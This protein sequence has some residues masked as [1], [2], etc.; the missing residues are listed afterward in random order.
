MD[1]AI[2]CKIF[3]LLLACSHV[4]PRFFCLLKTCIMPAF[5]L[6][7]MIEIIPQ[8]LVFQWPSRIIH[9]L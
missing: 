3:F 5:H 8:K 6:L 2:F 1:R 7:I 9:I 4:H